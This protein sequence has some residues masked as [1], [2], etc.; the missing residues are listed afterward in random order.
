MASDRS[1]TLVFVFILFALLLTYPI[2]G[3]VDESRLVWGMPIQFFYFFFIW[4]ALIVVV[5]LVV[6][7][8][9]N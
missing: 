9:K 7:K 1:S 8:R 2:M 5:A 3:I 6:R 4:M